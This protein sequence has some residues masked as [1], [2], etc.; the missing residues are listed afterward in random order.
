[1]TIVDGALVIANAYM[2]ADGLG[3]RTT[4][5]GRLLTVS[6]PSSGRAP[7]RIEIPNPAKTTNDTYSAAQPSTPTVSDTS[8]PAVKP[9]SNPPSKEPAAAENLDKNRAVERWPHRGSV[10][11]ALTWQFSNNMTGVQKFINAED[12]F[13]KSLNLSQ[14]TRNN[15]GQIISSTPITDYDYSPDIF[16]GGIKV[17]YFLGNSTSLG[18]HF[19]FCSY[20]QSLSVTI[21]STKNT[22]SGSIISTYVLGPSLTQYLYHINRFGLSL[23]GDLG[24]VF[25]EA[26]S[27]PAL[28][29]LRKLGALNDVSGLPNLVQSKHIVAN[30]SGIQGNIA[31]CANWF[32]VR[33]FSL[34]AGLSCYF[35]YAGLSKEIW[36][37]TGTTIS[38][39]VPAFYLGT[40]FCLFNR[41]SR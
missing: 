23:H 4:A 35:F 34:D 13:L 27:L 1:M 30:I 9:I 40:N 32:I 11:L 33:W 38:T 19:Y 28:D 20:D 26:S 22:G 21:G 2:E 17:E 5:T 25:G 3:F 6:V 29:S 8:S 10:S 14:I 36:P 37:N 41:A 24:F 39:I 12:A 7:I 18:L 15:S 31:L 16:M